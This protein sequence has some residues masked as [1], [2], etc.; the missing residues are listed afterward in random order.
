MFG[1]V[2][3]KGPHRGSY[4]EALRRANGG[5]GPIATRHDFRSVSERKD[6]DPITQKQLDDVRALTAAEM[7]G[8]LFPKGTHAYK[9]LTDNLIRAGKQNAE[10]YI[11]TGS[12]QPRQDVD[13]TSIEDIKIPDYIKEDERPEVKK[14]LKAFGVENMDDWIKLLQNSMVRKDVS[15]TGNVA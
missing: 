13:R 6:G 15:R 8:K 7:A 14:E 3:T 2:R 5:F 4:A 1:E 9:A 10:Q 12:V 11:R